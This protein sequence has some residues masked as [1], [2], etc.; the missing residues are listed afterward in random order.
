[1]RTINTI[2]V[3]HDFSSCSS[4]ALKDG[5]EL[6]IATRASLHLL[7]VEVMHADSP[8]KGSEDTVK[9]ARMKDM[10]HGA[11]QEAVAA[12]GR[13][14]SDIPSI[15]YCVLRDFAAAPS[16]LQYAQ[17]YSADLIVMGTHGRRGLPRKLIG[18]SAEEV[19]RL[20]G[21]PVLTVR[22]HVQLKPLTASVR[23]IL[24]PIDFSEHATYALGVA[25]DLADFFDARLDL[26]HV[27]EET[28][29][30]AFYNTGVFSVYDTNPDLEA[31]VIEHLKKLYA[32]TPGSE[33]PVRYTVRRGH[34]VHELLEAAREQGND[35]IVIAT[36]GLSGLDRA[37]MGSVTERIVRQAP[38]PVFTVKS[39]NL[40]VPERKREH[41]VAV[42]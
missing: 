33:G 22:E 5:I 27:V 18:S 26:V 11:I 23:S 25:K 20:A 19:V 6:A 41:A 13:Q 21:C 3:A 28:L 1:M 39:G 17:E 24:V 29:H 4:Q 8:L 32:E 10:L 16:I 40:R 14:V 35:L 9:A 37:I 7:Y 36:H 12:L 38:T 34:A 15:V 31:S 42:L 30:P 2:L